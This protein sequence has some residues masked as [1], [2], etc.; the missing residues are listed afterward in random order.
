MQ[1]KITAT[2]TALLPGQR[3]ETPLELVVT[4]KRTHRGPRPR[5]CPQEGG[6]LSGVSPSH[7][8]ALRI[9]WEV[10]DNLKPCFLLSYR[11]PSVS[12][13]LNPVVSSGVWHGR[14][15]RDSF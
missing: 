4:G 3:I 14:D 1:G 7:S 11:K 9:M 5:L 8:P 10:R 12:A 2:I 15:L 6:L 13:L